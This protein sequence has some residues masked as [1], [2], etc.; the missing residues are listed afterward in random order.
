MGLGLN[1]QKNQ[2]NSGYRSELIGKGSY[3]DKCVGRGTNGIEIQCGS[4]QEVI[5]G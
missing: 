4:V 1:F 5:R 3:G 2:D